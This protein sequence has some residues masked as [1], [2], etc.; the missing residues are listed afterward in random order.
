[1]IGE[2]LVR[3]AELRRRQGRHD[4]AEQLYADHEGDSSTLLGRAALALDLGRLEEAADFAD[5]YLRR[6]PDPNRLERSAGLEVA[7]RAHAGLANEERAL[8]ALEQLRAIASRAG[9]RPL[10]AAVLTSEATLAAGRGEHDP[11]RRSFEDAIDLLAACN[12]PF[13]TACVRL[14]LATA[15]RALGRNEAARRELEAALAAFRKLDAAHQAARAEAM[16]GTRADG[17][18]GELSRREL[19]VLVLIAEGLTNGEIAERLV[20]S[21]HTVHRHVA[22]LLRKLGL[23]S[24]AAAASLAGRHGLA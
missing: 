5:R 20:L 13:E 24:R 11:A 9:T 21:E 18:L 14:D 7:V 1:L 3:L 19:E 6:F 4:E 23:P 2:A 17:P 8:E 10:Q 12:A 15:L 16:L 22:N